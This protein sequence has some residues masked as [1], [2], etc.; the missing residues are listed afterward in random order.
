MQIMSISCLFPVYTGFGL[1]TNIQLVIQTII[2]KFG[3]INGVYFPAFACK[4][5]LECNI[6]DSSTNYKYKV[7]NALYYSISM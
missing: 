5:L 3:N 7:E 4:S 2:H 6:V 1:A